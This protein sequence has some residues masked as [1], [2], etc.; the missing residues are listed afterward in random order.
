MI[1]RCEG[2][3]AGNGMKVRCWSIV[4]WGVRRKKGCELRSGR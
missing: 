3:Y 2:W 4:E 1:Q